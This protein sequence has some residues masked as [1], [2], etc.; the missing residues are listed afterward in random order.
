LLVRRR[1]KG[2]AIDTQIAEI[3]QAYESRP[4][5]VDEE[6]EVIDTEHKSV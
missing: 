5:D 2:L 4:P 1:K 6:A 3:I